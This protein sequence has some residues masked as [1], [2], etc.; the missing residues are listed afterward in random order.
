MTSKGAEWGIEMVESEAR[1]DTPFTP[2]LIDNRLSPE[3]SVPSR[4]YSSDVR[5][6]ADLDSCYLPLDGC[7]WT[8]LI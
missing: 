3:L 2:E 1:G 7:F 8:T 6:S 4:M 5:T